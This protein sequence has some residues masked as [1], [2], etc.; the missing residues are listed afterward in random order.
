MDSYFL[1][2]SEI[3]ISKKAR[4]QSFTQKEILRNASDILIWSHLTKFRKDATA[5]QSFLFRNTGAR[6]VNSL[7]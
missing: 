6:S 5:P 7:P 1:N 3:Q 4:E 2:G